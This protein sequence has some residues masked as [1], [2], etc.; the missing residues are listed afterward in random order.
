MPIGDRPCGKSNK[1]AP[2]QPEC[3]VPAH[4]GPIARDNTPAITKK[5]A[6]MKPTNP[7]DAVLD[8]FSSLVNA[9]IN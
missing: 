1:C 2:N 7:E 3:E 5:K 8:A 4:L 9:I 6:E